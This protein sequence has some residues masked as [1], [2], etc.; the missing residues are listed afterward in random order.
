LFALIAGLNRAVR[1]SPLEAT[2]ILAALAVILYV[3]V[4][5]LTA[6]R[7]V[8]MTDLPFHVA[9]GAA[10]RHYWDP[11]YHF[12]EQFVL[13]PIAIPYM[14]INALVAAAM[15]VFPVLIAT[16][17]ALAI[18]LMLV[19]G[20]LAV[21]FHGAK[22]SPLLGLLG[23][24]MCWGHLTHWGFVNYV[25]ALGLFSMVLG[26][27][28][29]VLDDPT[30][31]RRVGLAVALVALFFTHIFRFP[32]ALAGVIGTAV[33][34]YP[35][36]RRFRAILL[37]MVPSLVFLALW[38]KLRPDTLDGKLDLGFHTE[39][40][41]KE[42]GAAITDGFVDDGVRSRLLVYFD[43]AWAVG[44]ACAAHALWQWR[45][46]LRRFTAWDVGVT[47]VPLSCAVV[48][49]VL[50]LVMPMWLGRWWYVYPREATAATIILIGACPDLPRTAWLRASLVAAMSLAALG[51]GHEVTAHYADFGPLTDDF[52]TITRQIPQA[53]KLFYM[54]LDRSGTRR[55]P[56]STPFI[57]LPAYVQAEKGGWLSWHFAIWNVLPVFYRSEG[58]PERVV[59]PR[60]P[61]RWEWT[62]QQQFNLSMTPF[63]DWFLVRTGASP[64]AMFAA[65]KTIKRVDHVGTWWL[66][67]RVPSE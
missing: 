3:I 41:A 52:Y 1:R 67:K 28:L 39:R 54:V 25:A 2:L 55:A 40:L 49:L 6:S 9:Q 30:L 64:D 50:F 33:V 14:A 36:T 23:L 47:L 44:A 66:Y 13:R 65:D 16:K 15:L 43:V 59:V 27:T 10:F 20:G 45:R 11:S 21:L 29:L 7:Y 51:V 35:A 18:L 31:G 61:P 56:A 62:Q 32:F 58:D 38:L 53:P 48:F 24:G 19:P 37:P 26:L 60:T 22:K 34:M 8:P 12:H 46:G 4:A 5:P 17:V 63:F 57:H 42:F